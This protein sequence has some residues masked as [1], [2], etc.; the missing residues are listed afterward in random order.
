METGTTNALASASLHRGYGFRAIDPPRTPFAPYR[1]RAR[2]C[3]LLAA[4]QGMTRETMARGE[5][6]A[7]RVA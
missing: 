2:S 5:W 4:W 7:Y 3:I 6:L 1:C